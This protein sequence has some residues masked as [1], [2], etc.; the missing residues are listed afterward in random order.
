M[1]F[2]LQILQR[3][4]DNIK[5]AVVNGRF[6]DA[7]IGS[8]RTGEALMKIRIF[9]EE[10]K[11]IEGNN[12][13]GYVGIVH[14]PKHETTKKLLSITTS[15]TDIKRIKRAS[16]VELTAWQR[17]RANKGRQVLRKDLSFTGSLESSIE[18]QIEDERNAILQFNNDESALIAHGQEQQITNI[19]NG[20]K[21]TT[22]GSGAVK[23]FTF[24]TDEL[25]QIREQGI[26]LINKIINDG[27]NNT[28]NTR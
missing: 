12:F 16:L 11:D 13:G 3:Q 21:G 24:N 19:R 10:N 1:A 8:L 4:V 20:G 27:L 17:K 2:D 26:E 25:N 9:G 14:K 7:L 28:A 23:I 15:R 5:N 6:G 18:T 22:K